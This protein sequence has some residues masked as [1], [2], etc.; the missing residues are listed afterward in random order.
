M[1]RTPSPDSRDLAR[2]WHRV[3]GELQLGMNAHT[4]ATYLKQTRAI[5]F[6][7]Q[8][9]VIE[10]PT[11][12]ACDYLE[13]QL[14]PRVVELLAAAGVGPCAVRFV[15]RPVAGSAAALVAMEPA[16]ARRPAVIGLINGQ[17]TFERYLAANGNR[18]ALESCRAAAGGESPS[19]PIVLYGQPGMGK[20]HLLHA[21]AAAVS[22]SGTV[23]CLNA[24]EYTNR[25]MAAYRDHTIPAFQAEMRNVSL[26]VLDDL[27][28]LA[29]KEGMQGELVHTIE[30]ICNNGGMVAV[31]SEQNPLELNL[32][33]RLASRLSQGFVTCVER[34]E[35]CERRE[36][37]S[38]RAQERNV[39]LPDWA[40]DRIAGLEGVSVRTLQ[41]AVNSATMLARSGAL[42]LARLDTELC[43]VAIVAAAPRAMS[44]REVVEAIGAH[45]EASYDEITGRGKT[46]SLRDARAAA[47]AALKER[48]RSN[49]QLAA[50]FGERHRS[51]VS[52]V[53]VRGREL[54]AGHE[55]LRAFLAG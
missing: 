35:R 47:F 15:P 30:A 4:F 43:R 52:G 49:A 40:L 55:R 2:T 1:P 36:F 53:A 9:W 21:L 19:G 42:D 51:T 33:D 10:A 32:L 12:F 45:F 18:L 34:F 54:L 39:E 25:Y 13:Q 31:A 8:T 37:A 24:E 22:A 5:A 26:F 3:S 27:Q 17:Y 38:Q 44:D 7:G 46:A 50:V 28:Y 20:S 41:G 48:G 16:P 6:D 23:V 14:S 29:G 11:P